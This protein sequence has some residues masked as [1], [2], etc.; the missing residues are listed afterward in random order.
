MH[1]MGAKVPIKELVKQAT[2]QPMGA[3]AL[4]R[5]LSGKYLGS[6]G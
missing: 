6:A 5:Y 4:L 1:G 2:D 3:N